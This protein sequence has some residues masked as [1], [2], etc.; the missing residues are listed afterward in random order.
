MSSVPFRFAND[1]N[2]TGAIK[3][4]LVSEEDYL[5]YRAGKFLSQFTKFE[6]SALTDGQTATTVQIGEYEDTI[7]NENLPTDPPVTKTRTF[8]AD[9][10][11]GPNSHAHVLSGAPLPPLIYE[12][13]TL[14]ITVQLVVGAGFANEVQS[15]IIIGNGLPASVAINTWP[16]ETSLVGNRVTWE[17]F[18][19]NALS[20]TYEVTYP[21][22]FSGTGA[23]QIPITPT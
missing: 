4:F 12:D 15:E 19:P 21:L 17:N 14:V 9:I 22:T 23:D 16:V 8:V 11:G 13:D 5:A 7:Y 1:T 18:G 6:S 20:G 2:N 3:E 10:N